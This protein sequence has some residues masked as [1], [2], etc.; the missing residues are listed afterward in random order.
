MVVEGE[1]LQFSAMDWL[2][3]VLI[4]ASCTFFWVVSF[5][6]NCTLWPTQVPNLISFID[7][8]SYLEK[9]SYVIPQA[10]QPLLVSGWLPSMHSHPPDFS[11]H[12]WHG[13]SLTFI[14][15]LQQELLWVWLCP[16][17]TM[18]GRFVYVVYTCSF[19][20]LT[21]ALT[22]P[23]YC[24]WTLVSSPAFGS[25]NGAVINML[26]HVFLWVHVY[27]FY[28]MFT[29]V[30]WPGPRVRCLASVAMTDSFQRE[31]FKMY[32]L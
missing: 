16:H 31:R 29:W 20:I 17:T 2:L 14:K 13:P 15:G 5:L 32:P 21:A 27:N 3:E 28:W 25:Y 18:F 30:E 10:S 23:L 24:E 11:H 4:Q 26:F 7:L 19:S 9:C 1:H 6:F 22:Y 8:V 12:S